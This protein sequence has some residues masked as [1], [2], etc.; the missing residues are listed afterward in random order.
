M[1]HHVPVLFNEVMA[2]LAPHPGGIYADGTLGGGGHAAGVLERSQP[3][4]ELFA[5]DQDLVALA[6]AKE[7]LAPYG[8][9][10]HLVHANYEALPRLLAERYPQGVDGILLDIG[11]SSPQI[12]EPSRGF[13]YMHDAPLD[14]RMNREQALDAY[15]I[16]NHYEKTE[17]ARI[18]RDYGEEKWAVRIAE[19]I[20]EHRRGHP[21]LSTLELVD[22]IERAIPKGAREKG[23]HVAKRTFQA[24]RIAVN[25][26]LGVLERSIEGLVHAL[27]P[28]G[29][30]AIITF[31]SLE[32]RIVKNTFKTL[33]SHCICPPKQPICT[34]GHV[35][36][37]KLITRK[38]IVASE[39]E[40]AEN[41][42]AA[43]AKLRIA[44]RLV[45]DR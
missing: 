11:V 30:L 20:D 24:L 3:D 44:E 43:S 5:V 37:V 38:P 39:T 14:M 33:A 31:H 4:G 32:D 34:C 2:G 26:E 36:E 25:D 6:A 7:R 22:I 21:I 40:N 16:V 9:R 15:Q 41:R 45:T 12:D 28:G 23:S 1:F 35:A 42:R 13:S 18:L 8:D 10:V 17:L 19:L 27:A 29:R